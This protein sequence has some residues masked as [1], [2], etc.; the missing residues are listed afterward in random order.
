[1][2]KK[3]SIGSIDELGD[4]KIQRANFL[5]ILRHICIVMLHDVW[6]NK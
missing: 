3:L 1:M 6:V 4:L 5:R 2:R